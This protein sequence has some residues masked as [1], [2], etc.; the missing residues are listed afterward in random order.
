MSDE[1][2]GLAAI[3]RRAKDPAITVT[4]LRQ[5][6]A[7]G[8]LPAEIGVGGRTLVKLADAQAAF[9]RV[10]VQRPAEDP[11]PAPVPAPTPTKPTLKVRRKGRTRQ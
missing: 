4:S 3:A 6:I 7:D 11:V 5:A 9:S 2:Q 8:R 1:P 10:E